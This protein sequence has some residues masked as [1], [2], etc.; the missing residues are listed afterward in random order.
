MLT[1]CGTVQGPMSEPTKPPATPRVKRN[2]AA[3]PWSRAAACQAVQGL[4]GSQP[5]LDA[6][7][8][9]DRSGAPSAKAGAPPP[10][11]QFH[12]AIPEAQR[13][14]MCRN[15]SSAVAAAALGDA[16]VSSEGDRAEALAGSLP[17][18][19]G[20]WSVQIWPEPPKGISFGA[21]APASA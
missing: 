1:A 5:L 3:F 4:L 6:G 12:L 17:T 19:Q 15:N 8:P 13:H 11:E 21:A 14:A 9:L 16:L 20:E 2:L 7:A 10:L 18:G